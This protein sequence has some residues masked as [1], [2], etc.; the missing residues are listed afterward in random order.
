MGTIIKNG[1]SYSSVGSS[2]S[3]MEVMTQAEYDKL[4]AE[5]TVDDDI[6]YFIS[7]A[8]LEGI[9]VVANDVAYDNS[10][11]G[12]E[13]TNLQSV[14]DEIND[15][16]N[17]LNN[18]F[19]YLNR[20]D[21]PDAATANG[22]A[23]CVT[24]IFRTFFS[25]YTTKYKNIKFVMNWYSSE[26]S[27]T[28]AQ[29]IVDGSINNGRATGI[30]KERSSTNV[31]SFYCDVTSGG[32]DTVLKKL[33]DTFLTGSATL[34]DA[35]SYSV[36]F[37]EAFTNVPTVYVWLTSSNGAYSYPAAKGLSVTTTGFSISQFARC[38]GGNGGASV[39]T[40]SIRWIA[41]D[42]T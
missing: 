15:N 31:Y 17:E 28:A 25:E 19:E 29:A 37:S 26:T 32:A 39:L 8:T 2:G 41:I 27:T 10:T 6:Y 30:I 23:N 4:V 35:T 12:L 5:G 38:N 40:G 14:V 11:S 42:L 9:D 16:V 24:Y 21:V 36:T 22:L 33:G 34:T 3:E 13:S 7:D 20:Y 18:N 1:I